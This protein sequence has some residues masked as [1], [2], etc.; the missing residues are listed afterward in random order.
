MAPA[1]RPVTPAGPHQPNARVVRADVIKL[2]DDLRQRLS[3]P[4]P[5]SIRL[6]ARF[7]EA[8]YLIGL[9]A[10]LLDDPDGVVPHTCAVC[11]RND[12]AMRLVGHNR[13]GGLA[14]ACK[15]CL[16]ELLRAI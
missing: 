15:Q 14:W 16:L 13:L 7:D 5:Y 8:A 2:C 1:G 10:A 11:D 9:A 6:E 12:R 3:V 4:V